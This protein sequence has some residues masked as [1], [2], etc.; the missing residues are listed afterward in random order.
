MPKSI[1]YRLLFFSMILLTWK[2]SY[3]QNGYLKSI[4]FKTNSSTIEDRFK[5][6]LKK[7][8]AQMKADT[9]AHLKLIGY[10]DPSGSEDYNDW[11]SEQRANSVLN[12]IMKYVSID[13]DKIHVEWLGES[14]D[15]FDL[16]LPKSNFQKRCVDIWLRLGLKENN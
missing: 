16:H 2:N 6:L 3:C 13:K 10:A 15:V 7:I 9:S 12:F 4:Y 5:P 11:L 14:S 8:A 1:F